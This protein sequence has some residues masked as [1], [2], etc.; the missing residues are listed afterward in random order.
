[1]TDRIDRLEDRIAAVEIK[2]T[3]LAAMV[4]PEIEY[5]Q[6]RR[7]TLDDRIADIERDV[8]SVLG[9]VREM[10]KGFRDFRHASIVFWIVTI[11]LIYWMTR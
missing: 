7:Q 8:R 4:E 3:E 2:T 5:V 1:M 11:G 9:P 10:S 6:K